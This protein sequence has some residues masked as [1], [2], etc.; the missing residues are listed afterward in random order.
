MVMSY[1]SFAFRCNNQ[2][3][4]VKERYRNI[5]YAEHEPT[6]QTKAANNLYFQASFITVSAV[7]DFNT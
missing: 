1:I 7:A 5:W 6:L 3:K 2:M 4:W